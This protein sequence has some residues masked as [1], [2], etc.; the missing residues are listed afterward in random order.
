MTA[1]VGKSWLYKYHHTFKKAAL[2]S[3]V[4][5]LDS[6]Q[7]VAA[8]SEIIYSSTDAGKN[9]TRVKLVGA[10]DQSTCLYNRKFWK[11]SMTCGARRLD[12]H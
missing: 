8:A 12:C 2:G 10:S 4:K 6:K 1:D 5:A 3:I 9:W 11:Q 7:L